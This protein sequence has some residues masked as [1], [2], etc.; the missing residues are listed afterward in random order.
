M[1]VDELTDGLSSVYTFYDPDDTRRSYGTFSILW[2]LA[3]AKRRRLA[4]VYLGYWI[5]E[6]RKMNYKANFQ[7]IEGLHKGVWGPL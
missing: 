2:Q 4:F 5:E 7:P 1:I 6:S 3:E